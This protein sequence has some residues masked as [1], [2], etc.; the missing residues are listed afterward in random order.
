MHHGNGLE[1]LDDTTKKLT[2]HQFRLLLISST[3]FFMDAY[4]IFIINLVTP[5]LG[6]VYYANS[7][8]PNKACIILKTLIIPSAVQG[9]LKGMTSVGQLIGQISFGYIGDRYGRK[10]IYGVEL[11]IICISTI[12]C[13]TSASAEAGLSAIAFLG[14]WRLI[15]GIGIGGDC[16][17]SATITSEW[18]V[19]HRRGQMIA[20][21]FSMQGFGNVAAA[22]VAMIVLACFKVPVENNVVNL[23]YVWRICLGLGAVPAVATIYARLTLP[24]SPRYSADVIGD[25]KAARKALEKQKWIEPDETHRKSIT[26]SINDQAQDF[27]SYFSRWSNLR[28]LLGT[29]LSWFLMD[30]AFYGTNLNQSIIL[31]QIGFAPTNLPPWDTLFK[32]A[33]GN[34]ILSVLGALPGYIVTVFTVEKLG[35]KPIQYLGFFIVGILYIVIGAAWYPIRSVNVA[36]FIVLFAIIQFFF[37]F[38]PNTTTFISPAEV[39]PTRHRSKAHGIAAASGKAGAIIATFGFNALADVGGPPGAATFLPNVLIIF[40]CVMLLGMVTSVWVPESKGRS[41]DYFEHEHPNDNTGFRAL[42]RRS[43]RTAVNE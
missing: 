40:G 9:P 33:T 38:G 24:E 2:W 17:L 27:R 37:N 18:A 11:I 4:D 23:D 41:L 10:K 12:F 35:R 34:L 6:Y 3:G 5:M 19:V 22:L 21:I 8:P 39:F 28:V 43:R 32:Q 16:P 30:I 14:F 13:A 42:F 36:L 25:Q 20:A 26:N 1:V 31:S 29:S 15:L 7:T